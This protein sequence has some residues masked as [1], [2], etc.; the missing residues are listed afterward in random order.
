[1]EFEAAQVGVTTLVLGPESVT[2]V[3]VR[4]QVP[5][6]VDLPSKWIF[7]V[8]LMPIPVPGIAGVS[9]ADPGYYIPI[10]VIMG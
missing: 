3:Y 7:W 6:G 1:V 4:L 5:E 8:E 9:F 10:K 2:P